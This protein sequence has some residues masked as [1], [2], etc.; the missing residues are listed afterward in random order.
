MKIRNIAAAALGMMLLLPSLPV[1]PVSVYADLE[2]T[3][4]NTGDMREDIVA[5][6]Q[7]GYR[8]SL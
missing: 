7:I 2:N 1:I 8:C 6:T 4:V 3:H 5:E